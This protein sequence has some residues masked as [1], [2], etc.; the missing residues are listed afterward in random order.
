MRNQIELRAVSHHFG[1]G[2]SQIHLFNDLELTIEGGNSYS[3]VGPS[4][5]GK[6]S[7]LTLTA[8]LEQPTSGN[9]RFSINGE[10]VS[11]Q[12]L[13]KRSGFIFQQFH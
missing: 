5:V 4:G 1:T 6:S 13:R 2:D 8:G 10:D 12:K 9:V 11:Q 3:I 7:L